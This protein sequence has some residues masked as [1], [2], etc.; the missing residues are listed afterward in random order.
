ME[1]IGC[2]CG[3]VVMKKENVLIDDRPILAVVYEAVPWNKSSIGV[4]I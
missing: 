1:T 2:C 4:Y 3:L